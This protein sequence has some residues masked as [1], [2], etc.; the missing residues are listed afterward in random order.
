MNVGVMDSAEELKAKYRKSA[1]RYLRGC[2]ALLAVAVAAPLVAFFDIRPSF[3]SM[4][5]WV[6]R[7]GASTSIYALL[8]NTVAEMGLRKLNKPGEMGSRIKLEVLSEVS[9]SFE[10][11]R[12][13][14]LVVTV[15]GTVIW[16]YGDTMIKWWIQ[17]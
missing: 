4:E 11:V 6:Q 7:S 16:G 1:K 13:T 15:L 2:W 12:W 8:S 14:A 3:E 10:I 17:P 5:V 9:R